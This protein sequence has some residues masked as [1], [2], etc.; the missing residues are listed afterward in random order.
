[1]A[2][3]LVINHGTCSD[4]NTNNCVLAAL[5]TANDANTSPHRIDIPGYAS[6][7]F[8]RL[9]PNNKPSL[10]KLRA[11]A[12]VENTC[13]V[14]F[15][16]QL[17]DIFGRIGNATDNPWDTFDRM[18]IVGWSRGCI[19]TWYQLY[20]LSQFG[21]GVF[22]AAFGGSK[23]QIHIFHIDPCFGP[24]NW[25]SDIRAGMQVLT[26]ADT[27]TECYAVNESGFKIFMGVYAAYPYNQ[28]HHC[29]RHFLPG[30]H[31]TGALSDD[32]KY[33]HNTNQLWVYQLIRFLNGTGVGGLNLGGIIGQ[34]N[35]TLYT[36]FKQTYLDLGS[37]NYR[38]NRA[39][40]KDLW[41]LNTAQKKDAGIYD[42][43]FF[44]NRDE[45]ALWGGV[46]HLRRVLKADPNKPAAQTVQ[47]QY[48]GLD[49]ENRNML[50]E[51]ISRIPKLTKYYSYL[52][53][54]REIFT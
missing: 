40:R 27:L 23:P 41:T 3:L 17:F 29:N 26:G 54:Y 22:D 9:A 11:K 35:L 21:R 6:G 28:N 16:N 37:K 1:M 13:S 18:I 44:M 30:K 50:K 42:T 20:Y 46:P 52:S 36:R 38:L 45:Y 39:Q 5:S 33:G 34:H 4:I 14:I 32:T 51:W 25:K 7:E 12:Y 53:D 19:N 31:A 43:W 47:I 48:N 24:S 49:P 10:S 2:D 8:N 15:R